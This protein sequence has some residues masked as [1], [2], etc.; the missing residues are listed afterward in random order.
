[1]AAKN[2]RRFEFKLG[3]TGIIVFISGM[4][5]LVF[6][7]FLFG[8]KV[9]KHIEVYP[10]QLAKGIPAMIKDKLGFSSVP[11]EEP[12]INIQAQDGETVEEA[13]KDFDLTFYDTLAGKKDAART[14]VAGDEKQNKLS[15]QDIKQQA[16]AGIKKTIIKPAAPM[17]KKI[18]SPSAAAPLPPV[19]DKK[20]VSLPPTG[21]SLKQGSQKGSGKYLVQVV[22]F[23]EKKKA[24]ELSKKLMS[25]GYKPRIIAADI[26]GKGKWFRVVL[27]GFDSRP[28][29]QKISDRIAKSVRGVNCVVLSE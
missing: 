18:E 14:T 23:P 26:P 7:S 22:S 4:S 13:K 29:A 21:D 16:Q 20:V 11:P 27:T 19:T 2:S 28:D 17:E 10:E 3:K 9:G 24:D 15:T 6:I 8:V 1:M 5:L 25:M 12:P